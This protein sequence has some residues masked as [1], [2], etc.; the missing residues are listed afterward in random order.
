MTKERTLVLI[1]PD[2]MQRSIVGKIIS[3]FEDTGLKIAAMKMVW[4]DEAM[5]SAHYTLDMAWANNVF[6][7][8]KAVYEKEKKQMEYKTPEELGKTV[9]SWLVK[10]LKESPIIAFILE[11]PHAIELVRKMIG[12]TEPRQA[13]PG[14]IRA[15]F[16]SIE[17]YAVADAKK[18]VIK[19][20]IHASDSNENAEREIALWFKPTEIHT[21]SNNL[22]RSL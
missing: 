15:D 13:L 19:N 8:T 22:E 12:H 20:L 17:S 4:A 3:R 6:N 1:K 16:M 2:A 10:F 11:G 14:T 21:Y 5:A 7:K 9:Q 18:R